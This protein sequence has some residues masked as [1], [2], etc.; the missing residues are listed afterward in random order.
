MGRFKYLIFMIIFI[1]SILIIKLLI[2]YL[3]KIGAVQFEREEG[4]D[5]HKKKEGTPRGG[6]F[7]F[8]IAPLFLLP[9]YRNRYFAFLYLAIALNGIVG[10]LDDFLTASKKH[11]T[12]LSI[13]WKMIFIT[14]I[15]VFLFFFGRELLSA[16]LTVGNISLWLGN[17]LYFILFMI[18]FV[19]APN[20]FNLTDG[21]DGLLGLVS[22]PILITI[23]IINKGI[24]R[25]FSIV[26]LPSIV[27]FLWFN[28][29]KASIF[30]GDTGASALGG[31][32][33][34]MSVI[35]KFEILLPLIAIIPVL[36]SFSVFI[37]IGYFKITKGKRVFKMAPIH[38][39]FE[40]MNWSETKI[41]FRFFVITVIFCALA[42]FLQRIL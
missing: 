41:D 31:A 9:F 33:A 35:G 39:H 17:L 20:A 26:L 21:L 12:G 4:P 25:D 11:S 34:A 13:R 10:L 24:V 15:S 42:L 22:I 28:S 23:A 37:Q 27:A 40:L 36:E 8:L 1:V 18:I 3:K 16:S 38:H 32:I 14:T 6:G 5:S 29:P 7:V 19:G 2:P 30:M